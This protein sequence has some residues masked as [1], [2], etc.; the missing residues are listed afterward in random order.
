VALAVRK[1]VDGAVLL[2]IFDAALKELE[3]FA[4]LN[5]GASKIV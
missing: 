1:A 3:D 5:A 2:F 4:D